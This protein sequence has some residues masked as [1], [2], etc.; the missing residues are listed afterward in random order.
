MSFGR[1]TTAADVVRGLDLSGTTDL[2]ALGEKVAFALH[3]PPD[4]VH[5][6]G[7]LLVIEAIRR[8][9]AQWRDAQPF[10][11]HLGRRGGIG[12]GRHAAHV[13]VVA[14]RADIGDAPALMLHRLEGQPEEVR[15]EAA[16]ATM[17]PWSPSPARPSPP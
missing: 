14:Q 6:D 17:G 12:T 9:D 10:L 4:I 13:D 7:E 1:T 3:R 16:P 11:E 2:T 8:D 5:D 15:A